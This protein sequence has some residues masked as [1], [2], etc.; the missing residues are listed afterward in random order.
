MALNKTV[1]AQ[2]VP[3]T[4]NQNRVDFNN[5]SF[6]DVIWN[7]GREV[8]WEKSIKCP[9][10][11]EGAQSH[12]SGCKNCGGTGRVFVNKINTRMILHSLSSDVKSLEWTMQ[13]AGT[14]SVTARIVD[15]LADNDKITEVDA[16]SYHSET[17]YPKLD[18]GELYAFTLYP[19]I[20]VDVVF[21]Y[22]NEDTALT[23]LEETVDYTI[24]NNIFSLVNVG[25]TGS[26]ISIR[27][28][29]RPVFYVLDIP[30]ESMVTPIKN[31]LTG[32]EEDI[33][34]P[35]HAIARRAHYVLDEENKAGTR[36]INNDY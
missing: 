16:E 15:K 33:L 21:L 30:R 28:K 11:S 36:I 23:K 31:K 1:V 27:Y 20:E 3:N 22:V 14:V 35:I 7:K 13:N 5:E 10:I 29:H 18:G 34:M 17:L 24:S 25:L 6:D 2:T 12:L 4:P 19:P 8:I 32:K 26:Q 9:C